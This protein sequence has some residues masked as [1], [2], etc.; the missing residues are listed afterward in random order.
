[1]F[2]KH[3][4]T[5]T[6]IPLKTSDTGTTALSFMDDYKVS[7]LPIVNNIDFLGLISD[8]DIYS[9]DNFGEAVGNHTLSLPNTFVYNHQHILEIIK[10]VATQKLSLIPVLDNK[11]KYHL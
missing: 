1:M 5:D 10:I 9:M 7:H 11:K 6:I 2:A 3:L 4:I 8:E